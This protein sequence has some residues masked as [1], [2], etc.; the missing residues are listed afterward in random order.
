MSSSHV[1]TGRGGRGTSAT[2]E[3]GRLR[4]QQGPQYTLIPLAAVQEAC[5]GDES[6]VEIVLTDGAVHRVKGANPTAAAAFAAALNRALPEGRDPAGSALV[7]TGSTSEEAEPLW[8]GDD[9]RASLGT[10]RLLIVRGGRNTD[11]PLA[12]VHEARVEGEQLLQVVLTDG[13]THQLPGGKPAA[14]AAFA[15]A[16]NGALPGER[17]PAGSA[18]VTTE[19]VPGGEPFRTVWRSLIWPAGIALAYLGYTIWAG[20]TH[21][22]FEAVS[23]AVIGIPVFLGLAA[24]TFGVL[25]ISVRV[26]LARRGIT[27]EAVRAIDPQGSP[28]PWYEFTAT[29]GVTYTHHT[30]KH[31]TPTLR[32]VY[33]PL[34]PYRTKVPGSLLPVVVR[35]F[36]AYAC[37]FAMLALAAFMTYET[38]R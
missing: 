21:G 6:T 33:D 14:T 24:V 27:V 35:Y 26:A 18:L 31:R 37:A 19:A 11:I 13:A 7:T 17:H 10:D 34:R 2:L 32:V 8:R 23:V 3:A 29:D 16:V 20:I 36:A 30:R 15:A 12:A 22:A 28:H 5:A 38:F 1:L 4:I 9:A 25:A